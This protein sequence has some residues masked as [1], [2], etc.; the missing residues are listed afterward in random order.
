MP[1]TGTGGVEPLFTVN[2]QLRQPPGPAMGPITRAPE[3]AERS[4]GTY[5]QRPPGAF[6]KALTRWPTAAEAS[7]SVSSAQG[8]LLQSLVPLVPA[9]AADDADPLRGAD[10][11]LVLAED[12]LPRGAD[13]G[14]VLAEQA[15]KPA[16]TSA[17]A[18]AHSTDRGVSRRGEA[19]MLIRYSSVLIA[20]GGTSG[21][22][23]EGPVDGERLWP[24]R[25]VAR[26]ERSL[27]L[28]P[29]P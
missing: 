10:G 6:S 26:R 19:I 2:L 21:G 8:W 16:S 13:V 4:V 1:L 27:T 22:G 3:P 29:L 9:L 24:C 5:S 7:A 28:P 20:V 11:G 12:T 23:P 17:A 15:A 18:P 25:R 14:L